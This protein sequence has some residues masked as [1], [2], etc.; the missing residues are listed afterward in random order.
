MD[1]EKKDAIG[2]INWGE[3]RLNFSNYNDGRRLMTHRHIFKVITDESG[4]PVCHY[5]VIVAIAKCACGEQIG[6]TEIERRL[7]ATSCLS[8]EDAREFGKYFPYWSIGKSLKDYA[9]ALEGSDA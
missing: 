8:A 1:D 9:R 5:A 4:C 3:F 2:L 7:N 6:P